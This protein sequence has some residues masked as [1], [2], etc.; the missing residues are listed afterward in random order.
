MWDQGR[1]RLLIVDD[2]ADI[3]N[4]VADLLAGSAYTFT[5]CASYGDA[6]EFA[7]SPGARIELLLCDIILPP[8]H[9]RD[10]ANRLVRMYPDL[11]VLFMSGYPY[12]LLKRHSLLPQ[13]A[14]FLSKPF[15]Q[16][17]LIEA[18]AIL[19]EKGKPWMQAAAGNAS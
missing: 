18:L 2:E 7:S 5:I 3:R 19:A 14:A 12:K 13:E 17:Q 16:A 6:V 1:M 9:G 11:K 4:L 15:A 10:L 8:F